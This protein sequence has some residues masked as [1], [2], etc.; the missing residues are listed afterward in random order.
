LPGVVGSAEVLASLVPDGPGVVM[1]P[2]P[3]RMAA[4]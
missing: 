2:L 3:Q 1:A 4:E